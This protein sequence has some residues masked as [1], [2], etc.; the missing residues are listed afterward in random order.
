LPLLPVTA[1]R[2]FPLR[3]E[4][5]GDADEFTL[6]HYCFLCFLPRFDRTFTVGRYRFATRLPSRFN[7]RRTCY[8]YTTAACPGHAA[9]WIP[10]PVANLLPV[11]PVFD[12]YPGLLQPPAAG[13]PLPV[14]VAIS[15]QTALNRTGDYRTE[16][17]RHLPHRIT[18]PLHCY[19]VVSPQRCDPAL[20]I[21]GLGTQIAFPAARTC[22]ICSTPPRCVTPPFTG[23]CHCCW[24][25]SLRGLPGDHDGTF[26]TVTFVQQRS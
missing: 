2:S 24:L 11:V 8:V 4:P 9:I 5:P 16:L 13:R 1:P 19:S 21:A 25:P 3:V 10:I 17:E 20:P 22:T 14:A 23:R 26:P 18:F 7:Y 6:P 15:F 12:S